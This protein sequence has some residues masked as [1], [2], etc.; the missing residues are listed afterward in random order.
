MSLKAFHIIFV[1]FSSLTALG[2]GF[3]AI[4]HYRLHCELAALIVGIASLVG[5]AML[6]IYGKWFL[7]KLRGVSYL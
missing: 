7:R 5:C 4:R 2:F 6:I 1:I 3:W